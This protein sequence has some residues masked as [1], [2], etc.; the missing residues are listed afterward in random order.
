MDIDD[1]DFPLVRKN[2]NILS[3]LI[4]IL[5]YTNAQLHQLNFLGIDMQLDGV[6]LYQALFLGYFYF[7]WRY[8]TKLN[9]FGGF[10][11]DFTNYYLVSDAG[12]RKQHNFLKYKESF[13]D[14][15]ERLRDAYEAGDK[16]LTLSSFDVVRLSNWPLTRLRLIVN[17]NASGR[18]GKEDQAQFS[19]YHDILL[20]RFYVI[21]KLISFSI[22]EDKFGDYLFPLVAVLLN[23]GFFLL[24]KEWQGSVYQIFG[25]I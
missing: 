14:K 5:A 7:I 16:F 6:K 22:K 2:L 24:K 21:R 20:S 3:I 4:L 10:W 23:V 15:S 17:F 13:I 9:F 25:L 8:W 19:E 18:K 12:V 1:N 11:G